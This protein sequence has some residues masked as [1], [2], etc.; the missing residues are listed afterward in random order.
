MVYGKGRF[1]R[2]GLKAN[3]IEPNL[4]GP[5]TTINRMNLLLISLLAAAGVG[6]DPPAQSPLQP[7]VISKGPASGTYQAFPDVCRLPN[8]DLFCV[9]YAGYGHVSLPRPDW[10]R[11][12]RIC[13]VRS[14]DEGRTW[15]NPAV[16]YDG[17]DDDRDPHVARTSDGRVWCSFF[18]YRKTTNGVIEY[19]ASVVTSGDDGRTWEPRHRVLAPSW[20]CSAPVRELPDGTRLLGVYHEEGNTAYGGV[21]RSVDQGRTWSGPIAIDPGSGV[22]LDAETDVLRLRDG[23]LFAALRGDK[24]NMHFATSRDGGL[25]WSGVR[26]IGFAGHAPHLNRHSSGAIVLVHRLPGTAMHVSRDEAQTWLGPFAIDQ[27]I[28]AYASTVELKDGTVL[29]VYYEE[30]EGSAIRARR[31]RLEPAGI[32]FL[33]LD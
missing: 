28:G 30:G 8:G 29:V 33:P 18:P 22:R 10:P 27:T 12:G 7:K 16:A 13:Q 14:T 17:P 31:F 23:T 19:E 15:S 21:L 32:Q 20:A 26:D 2:A 5:L 9:F 3:R 25:T 1:R 11:G 4:P 6:A 24:V